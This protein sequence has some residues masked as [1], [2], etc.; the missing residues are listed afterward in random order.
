MRWLLATLLSLGTVMTLSADTF[1]Y[2]SMAPEQKIQVFRLDT[3]DG[4]LTPV[5]TV[6]VEST[7]G[8]LAVHGERKLRSASLR[9]HSTLASFGVDPAS[10]KLKQLSSAALGKGENAAYVATDRSGRW[11]LSASY[12]AGKVVVHRINDD[13]T[14]QTP[15]V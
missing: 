9:H 11:L 6:D 7:P 14:I 15:A 12:A 8:S 13:G 3:K 10:G 2:V 1:V 5:E 4:K